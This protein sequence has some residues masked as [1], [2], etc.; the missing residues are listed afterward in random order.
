MRN[1]R[2]LNILLTRELRAGLGGLWLFI[3]CLAVG[4]ATISGVGNIAASFTAGL[5]ANARALL[6]GDIELRLIQRDFNEK[7]LD[8]LDDQSQEMSQTIEMRAMARPIKGA[9]KRTLIELKAVDEYYPL[10]GKFKSSSSEPL[11][12]L[13][14]NTDKTWGAVA[15]SNLLRRLGLKLNDTVKVGAALFIIRATVVSEPDRAASFA[16][17][18]PRLLVAKNALIATKLIKPGS[19]IRYHSRIVLRPDEDQ[20]SWRDRLETSFPSAGWRLRTFT[21]AAPGAQRFIDRMALFLSFV[22]LTVLLVSGLAIASTINSY[23]E[24]KR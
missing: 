20:S 9:E 19:Q 17:F 6:G 1:L 11:S 10:V 22:G 13:L 12:S 14:R 3:A 2:I 5:E 16:S 18:G 15:D 4:I 21:D 23:L 8:W 7:H 24:T